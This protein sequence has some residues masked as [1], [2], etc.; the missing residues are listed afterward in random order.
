MC[1]LLI[2]IY[3]MQGEQPLPGM[4]LQGKLVQED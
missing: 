2:G 3:S 4:E 1:T